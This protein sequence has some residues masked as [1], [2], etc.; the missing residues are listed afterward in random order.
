MWVLKGPTIVQTCLW[1][2]SCIFF[3]GGSSWRVSVRRRVPRCPADPVFSSVLPR[4]SLLL[5][6]DRVESRGR[7]FRSVVVVEV[8]VGGWAGRQEGR[9]HT[10]EEEKRPG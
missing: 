8:V 5:A 6:P 7:H 9:T 2:I 3:L 1:V 10:G 4:D